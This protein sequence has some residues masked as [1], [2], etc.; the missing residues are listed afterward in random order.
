M[1]TRRYVVGKCLQAAPELRYPTVDALAEDLRRLLGRR[2]VSARP[3]TLGYV[4]S[5]FVSRHRS[6]VA[7]TC[8]AA[9]LLAAAVAGVIYQWRAAETARRLAEQRFSDVRHLATSL[10]DV[11]TALADLAGATD[12][13]RAIVE[14]ASRYLDRLARDA[15]DDSG[16]SVELAES[17]RRVGDMLGNP[18]VPNLGRREEA[19]EKYEAAARL[20]ANA[21]VDGRGDLT[22]RL[23]EARLAASQ[24][25][26]L[27]AQRRHRE[28][29]EAYER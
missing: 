29:R 28:A 1:G 22:M 2:P 24:G 13:R 8:A 9:V 3:Q 19:L 10:F 7:G 15:T 23:A 16:L 25:D 11:D 21:S 20:L 14:N 18:N 27:L 26:V 6:L 4:A 5:R 17:Y 12:A